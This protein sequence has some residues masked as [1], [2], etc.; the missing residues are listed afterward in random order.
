MRFD[1]FNFCADVPPIVTSVQT[2]LCTLYL[3]TYF[4]LSP[5]CFVHFSVN[6]CIRL[7]RDGSLFSI[8]WQ[9]SMAEMI[10]TP[11]F[12]SLPLDF[13]EAMKPIF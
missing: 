7:A 6:M 13:L 5:S 4:L 10:F 1:A 9:T 8:I 2:F 3:P 12:F 11:V